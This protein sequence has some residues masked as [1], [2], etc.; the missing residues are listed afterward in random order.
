ML[1]R[2]ILRVLGLLLFVSMLT[3][4]GNA[5][6]CS[7]A[8][9]KGLYGAWLTGYDEPGLYLQGVAQ[10]NFNGKGSFTGT[11]TESDDGTIY[12][13]VAVMGT[14]AISANCTG[15]G[16]IIDQNGHQS[17]YNFVVD[18]VAKHLEMVVADSGHGTGSGEADALGTATCSLSSVKGSY[19]F[20]GGGY[21]VGTGVWQFGGQYVL[22]GAGGVSGTE[23]SVVAGV[24]STAS[25]NGTYTVASGCTGTITVS[26]SAPYNLNIVF[27]QGAKAFF[28]VETDSAYVGTLVAHQ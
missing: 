16:T 7:N 28:A 27:I 20:H 15:S 17:H 23:T 11:E 13:D 14:Y 12:N 10:L 22:D 5:A 18:P 2:Q 3:A 21:I 4:V 1:S 19:G 25:V 6:T 8:S 24:P 9:L 26:S